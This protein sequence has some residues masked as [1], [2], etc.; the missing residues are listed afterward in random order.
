MIFEH[1]ET[2]KKQY[3]DKYVLVDESR[4]EL[5]RFRGLTGT[6]KTVNMSGRA[7]VEF[8]GYNN[9]GWYDID[10]SYLKV[11]DAP[12]AKPVESKKDKAAAPQATA[13]GQP[14]A[15]SKPVGEKPAPKAAAP[16]AAGKGMSMA[17]ILAAARSKPGAA[18]PSEPPA[19]AKPT[20]AKPAAAAPAAKADPT[21]MSVAD[22]IAAAKGNKPAASAPVAKATAPPASAPPAE[23]AEEVAVQEVA[24]AAEELAVAPPAA[25]AAGGGKKSKLGEY[26]TVAAIVEY[27]RQVDAK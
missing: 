12:I 2:L 24:P 9:I 6:V 23:V 18:A 7:L 21:K 13:V 15:A 8:D 4:P 11:V 5:R 27:C 3:T 1:I 19:P 14:S 26:T 20:P 25:A 10:P 16:A 17:D 22:M